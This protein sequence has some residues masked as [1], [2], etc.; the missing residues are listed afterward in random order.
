MKTYSSLKGTLFRKYRFTEY[1]HRFYGTRLRFLHSRRLETLL[2]L[3][4]AYPDILRGRTILEVGCM[5][6]FSLCLL[7]EAGYPPEQYVGVDVF[8]EDSEPYARENA[9]R[10]RS[11]Y[12]VEVDLH[13]TPAASFVSSTRFD[14]VLMLETLEHLPDEEGGIRSLS[15]LLGAG[16]YLLLSVPVEFGLLFGFREAGRWMTTGRTPYSV[17]EFLQAL[18]GK[19]DTISRE[20]GDHKGYDYRR[21]VGVLATRGYDC[22]WESLYPLPFARLAYGYVAL[23]RFTPPAG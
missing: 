15:R 14:T 12:G 18:R 11:R 7:C 10:I 20:A 17:K 5:D 19:T 6:L 2:T 21:T 22:L 3:L 23:F 13:R 9:E 8:W 4:H 16:G 1:T